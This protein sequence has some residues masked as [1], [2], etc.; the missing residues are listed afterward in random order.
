MEETIMWNRRRGG[1]AAEEGGLPARSD[2][3]KLKSG[4][5][6]KTEQE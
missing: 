5:T 4:D 2:L 6:D 3:E 1:T